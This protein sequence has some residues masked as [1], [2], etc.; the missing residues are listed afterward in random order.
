[1]PMP[2]LMALSVN[3]AVHDNFRRTKSLA[4]NALRPLPMPKS[5]SWNNDEK[6][7]PS[8]P[9]ASPKRM[10]NMRFASKSQNNSPRNSQSVGNGRGSASNSM[11]KAHS[12]GTDDSFNKE[13]KLRN[14]LAQQRRA[15]FST[16]E[17]TINLQK[18]AKQQEQRRKSNYLESVVVIDVKHSKLHQLIEIVTENDFKIRCNESQLFWIMGK[19]WGSYDAEKRNA[20]LSTKLF[21]LKTG[22]QLLTVGGKKHKIAEI[23]VIENETGMD[24]VSVI[25]AKNDC[26]FA[27]DLLVKNV[28]SL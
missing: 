25:V 4:E 6:S 14:R 17:V 11:V 19:G 5:V 3:K 26:F 9:E 7:P 18:V 27:N 21:A 13:E 12:N 28:Q 23:N 24:C 1:M 22:E 8:S 16:K 2:N 10:R 15:R 20:G